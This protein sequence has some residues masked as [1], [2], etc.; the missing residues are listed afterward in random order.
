MLKIKLQPTGKKKH[1][2]FRIVVAEDRS[3]RDGKVLDTLGTYDPHQKPL[4]FD[5]DLKKL[6]KW[7]SEGAQMTETVS[8]LSG[9]A[10][11]GGFDDL[12]KRK[13]VSK[14]KKAKEKEPEKEKEKEKDAGE[15]PAEKPPEKEKEQKTDP[16]NK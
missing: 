16:P 5:I 12:L 6:E 4:K 3:S 11:K 7:I 15:K 2:M 10:K 9:R 13:K 14:H 1:R 8:S